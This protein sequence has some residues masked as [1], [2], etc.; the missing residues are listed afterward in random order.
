MFVKSGVING[1]IK[2]I[3]ETKLYGTHEEYYH[4]YLPIHIKK[5]K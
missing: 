1:M 3:C 5:R 2:K 4:N